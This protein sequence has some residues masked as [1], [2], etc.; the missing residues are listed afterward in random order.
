M[1]EGDYGQDMDARFIKMA[2]AKHFQRIRD[3]EPPGYEMIDCEDCGR[4][5]PPARRQATPGC[6]RCI[7]CQEKL[8][9]NR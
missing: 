9:R 5:I 3:E 6:K 8:E 7:N 4:E 2:L 1:D